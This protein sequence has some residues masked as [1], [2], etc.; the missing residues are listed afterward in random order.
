MPTSLLDAVNTVIRA[1]GEAPVV[2]ILPTDE[3]LPP[4][5]A[6]ALNLIEEVRKEMQVRGWWFNRERDYPLQRTTDGEYT[7]PAN[8]SRIDVSEGQSVRVTQRGT[9]LYNLD[10][11]SFIFTETDL[12]VDLVLELPWDD[13]PEV[14]RQYIAIV[15][16]RRFQA[17][18]LSSPNLDG[19]TQ[20]DEM[21]ALVNLQNAEAEEGNHSIFNH[22][23]AYRALDRTPWYH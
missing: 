13:L 1:T 4:N 9:K 3:Q 23:S 20:V 14:A 2:S 8:T 18:Y 16:A 17:R 10:T 21:R 22:W 19:F 15:A 7:L 6:A 5:I 11:H 12:K